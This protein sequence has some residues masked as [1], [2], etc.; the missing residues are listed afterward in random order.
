MDGRTDGRMDGWM[1]GWMDGKPNA[2]YSSIM[3]CLCI[4]DNQYG[5]SQ[6]IYLEVSV[7]QRTVREQYK[8]YNT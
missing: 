2:S 5:E 7:S 6:T 3:S 4:E 8:L 1:D